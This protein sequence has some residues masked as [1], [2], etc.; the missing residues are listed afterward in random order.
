MSTFATTSAMDFHRLQFWQASA[1][2]SDRPLFRGVSNRTDGSIV[3]GIASCAFV[4]TKRHLPD[5][6]LG[7]KSVRNS[8]TFSMTMKD[9]GNKDQIVKLRV[10]GAERDMFEAKAANYGSISAMIRDAV[11]HYDD[12]L[13]KRRIESMNLL[14]PLISKHESD[15]NRIGNNLNQIAHYCNLLAANGEYNM[16]VIT[17]SVEPLLHQLL[18]LNSDIAATEHKIFTRI[19]SEK[20]V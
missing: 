17:S 20:P 7:G 15:L 5:L 3:D 12:T 18:S 13:M 1:N 8:Q 4:T 9:S 10:S 16:Q 19:F 11:A 6:R 2:G 14:Y